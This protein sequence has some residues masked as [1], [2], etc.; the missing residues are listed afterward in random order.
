V[1]VPVLGSAAKNCIFFYTNTIIPVLKYGNK[2]CKTGRS[3]FCYLHVTKMLTLNSNMAAI[4]GV[5][6]NLNT[7]LIDDKG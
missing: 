4:P 5:L 2:P 7:L 1:T 3:K 6:K